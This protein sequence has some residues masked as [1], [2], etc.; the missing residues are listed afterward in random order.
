MTDPRGRPLGV[1]GADVADGPDVPRWSPPPGS[2]ATTFRGRGLVNLQNGFLRCV[3]CIGVIDARGRL[4]AA[5]PGQGRT[6]ADRFAD[7]DYDL[8]TGACR[9]NLEGGRALLET[10]FPVGALDASRGVA[11][12]PDAIVDTRS[13]PPGVP[14]TYVYELPIARRA[15]AVPRRSAAPL[16]CVPAVPRPG[17]RGVR[18]AD[19]REGGATERAAGGP[20][21][22]EAP[23]RRRARAGGGADRVSAW[24][25]VVWSAPALREL[26]GRARG[27]IAA[28]GRS[29]CSRA[30][31]G[32]PRRGARGRRSSPWWAG[33]SKFAGGARG[34]VLREARAGETF[35][36]EAIVAA[37]ACSG[38]GTRSRSS[39]STVAAIPGSLLRGC[40]RAERAAAPRASE[41]AMRRAAAR[42]R[43]R[44]S[45]ARAGVL[46]RGPRPPPRRAR[47]RSPRAGRSALPGGGRRRSRLRRRRGARAGDRTRPRGWRRAP[48]ASRRGGRVR[49]RGRPRA[50]PCAPRRR[51]RRGHRGCSRSPRRRCASSSRR[52]PRLRRGAAGAR[53]VRDSRRASPS[54]AV[55]KA[56]AAFSA[57]YT[58]SRSRAR[59]SSS[60]RPLAS[61]AGTAP[62]AAPAPTTTASPDSCDAA[63]WSPSARTRPTPRARFS[64]RRAASIARSPC[65]S[66]RVRRGPSRVELAAKSPSAPSSAPGAARARRRV[67]GKRSRWRRARGAA[68]W[69]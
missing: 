37:R 36:E 17:V 47:A 35:G 8:D 11:K 65:A 7:G 28:A 68:A 56:R 54:G 19:G 55:H 23:R 60:T 58:A 31:G 50:A 18:G 40:S 24:P 30:A 20:G 43:L 6:R 42:E 25:E 53:E 33:S 34:L 4:P 41:L 52:A 9:S 1:F 64:W 29:V 10:Y 51:S 2:G 15:L 46:R 27:E 62:G 21:D 45:A 14:L 66:P 69:R 12:A 49:G 57:T 63:T 67:R 61:D 39:G 13:A 48:G 3:R 59:S 22:A 5:G 44:S 26:D 38:G 32:V 16:P